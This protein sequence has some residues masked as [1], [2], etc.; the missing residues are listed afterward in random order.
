MTVQTKW[1]HAFVHGARVLCTINKLHATR[2]HKLRYNITANG[3]QIHG[4]N[5]FGTLG[6]AK[7][8]AGWYYQSVTGERWVVTK[9]RLGV[10]KVS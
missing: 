7:R 10:R 8:Y 1:V 4:G 6:A 9:N 3:V 2:K 5:A